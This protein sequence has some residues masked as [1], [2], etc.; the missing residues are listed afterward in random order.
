[1]EIISKADAIASGLKRYFTGKPC[2][3]GHID[4]RLVSN[5]GCITCCNSNYRK[6]YKE[7]P[8]P[9]REKSSIWKKNNPDKAKINHEN[10]VKKN[11]DKLKDHQI[12]S[13]SK[14]KE[15]GKTREYRQK[16]TKLDPSFKLSIY[17]R[18]RTNKAI[19]RNQ[20]SGSAV[21]DLGCSI[22]FLKSYLESRFTEG[23]SWD[24]W[25]LHGWH[26]DHV[27]PLASFDLLNPEQFKIAVNYNNL[28]PMW[29]L[30]NLKKGKKV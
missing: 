5:K 4:E 30:D 12:R 13:S 26:I 25:S 27:K 3:N 23:M 18:N 14:R 19:C 7:N 24:N 20:K 8:I 2:K 9:G 11:P 1:M 29:A 21:G 10:W 22:E 16:R 17:L 6:Y 15:S 28:Q